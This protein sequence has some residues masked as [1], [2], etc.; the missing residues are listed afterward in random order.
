MRRRELAETIT[1]KIGSLLR[2]LQPAGLATPS[3]VSIMVSSLL[4]DT[5]G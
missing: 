2:R 1:D 4:P 5:T 3:V